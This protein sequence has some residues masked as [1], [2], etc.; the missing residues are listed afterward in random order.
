MMMM[1]KRTECVLYFQSSFKLP[2]EFVPISTKSSISL[3]NFVLTIADEVL[4]I[5]ALLKREHPTP[6]EILS[7]Y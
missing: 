5:L 2:N 6:V 7:P 3:N 4:S 1:C